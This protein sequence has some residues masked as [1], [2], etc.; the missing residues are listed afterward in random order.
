[1]YQ[2][3]KSIFSVYMDMISGCLYYQSYYITTVSFWCCI[4]ST[5]SLYGFKQ[6]SLIIEEEIW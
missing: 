4:T 5:C 1:L 3:V 6:L 2:S